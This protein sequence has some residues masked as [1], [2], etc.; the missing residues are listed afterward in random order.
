MFRSYNYTDMI[1]FLVGVFILG[2]MM[3]PI[4]TAVLSVVIIIAYFY[5][6]NANFIS[7]KV[8]N[9]S[10]SDRRRYALNTARIYLAPHKSIWKD[11]RLSNRLCIL[12][13]GSDGQSIS[14]VESVKPF[15]SLRVLKSKIHSNNDLWNMLCIDFSHTTSFDELVQKFNRF[16]VDIS[17]KDS[18]YTVVQKAQSPNNIQPRQVQV[19]DIN[20]EVVNNIKENTEKL[21]INNASEVEIT[22]LP[23]ISIVMAKKLVKK[24]DEIKGFKSVDDVCIF[25]HLR[26][27]I[28]KQIRDL[29]CVN[30]MQG[31]AKPQ[32]NRERSI[33]L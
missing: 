19:V 15:R 31:T 10:Q 7:G 30:K 27:H 33:D 24:R 20:N 21:D 13:L 29:I 32:R 23:G 5:L 16:N 28:E 26:P 8:M 14:A 25:L 3:F 1:A 4:Q 2:F 11:L 6:R 18:H 9:E 12:L 17:I 22:S